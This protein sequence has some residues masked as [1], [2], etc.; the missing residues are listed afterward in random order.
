[1]YDRSWLSEFI[2]VF[3]LAAFAVGCMAVIATVS[4]GMPT[5]ST[6]QSVAV[7][8]SPTPGQAS[9]VETRIALTPRPPTPVP[10]ATAGAVLTPTAVEADVKKQYMPIDG[11]TLAQQADQLKGRKVLVT[12]VL[13]YMRPDGESTWVQVK[14]P[15][16]VFIDASFRGDLKAIR[17][18]QRVSLY[19]TGAGTTTIVANDGKRYDQPFINPADYVDQA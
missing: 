9:A 8:V 11:K 15:D 4:R 6:S 16:G 18:S 5:P 17:E 7:A 12:G 3:A 14:T 1:M 2:L 19:G 13:F 10:T